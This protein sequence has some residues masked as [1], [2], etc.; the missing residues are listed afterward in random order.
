MTKPTLVETP[1]TSHSGKTYITPET[2]QIIITDIA[3]IAEKI[4]HKTVTAEEKLAMP[5]PRNEMDYRK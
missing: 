2:T 1:I 4:R 3:S 5:D